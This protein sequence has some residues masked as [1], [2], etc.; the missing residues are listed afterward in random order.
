M[1]YA[2]DDFPFKWK[3]MDWGTRPDVI[4]QESQHSVNRMRV[5][6]VILLQL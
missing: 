6:E 5:R 4:S 1:K 3:S 2:L